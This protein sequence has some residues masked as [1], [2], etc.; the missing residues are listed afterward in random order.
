MTFGASF[1]APCRGRYTTRSPFSMA[2]ALHNNDKSGRC[3]AIG[4][5]QSCIGITNFKSNQVQSEE[6][7]GSR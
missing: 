1:T 3:G 6:K 7:H 4:F 2:N 5:W